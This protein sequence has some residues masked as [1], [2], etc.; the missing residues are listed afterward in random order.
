MVVLAASI[1]TRQGKP[2]LSR[3]FQEITKERV[4]E[5][6][7]KF[8][9]LVA[10][11]S[12]DHTFVEDGHVRFVYKP[13]DNYYI[14]LIT[15]KQSNI[16]QDLSSLNL[17]AQT[18]SS[19]LGGSY[20]E[21]ELYSNAFEIIS[22]FD[23]ILTMGYREN[24]T[25]NQVET[26]LSMESHE[27]RI[28]E[29][30][31]RNKEIEA[32]EERKRRAKEISNR[33]RARKQGIYTGMDTTVTGQ[34]MPGSAMAGM[35]PG[36]GMGNYGGAGM[37]GSGGQRFQGSSDP[38]VANA[39]NS[40]YGHGSQ[41]AGQSYLQSHMEIHQSHVQGKGMKLSSGGSKRQQSAMT[42]RSSGNFARA[43]STS[44]T[45]LEETKL[46]N[47]GILLNIKESCS[48]EIT[49]DGAIQS[50]ELKGVLEVRV[51]DKS[52]AHAIFHLNEIIDP[53]DK[54]LQY[55]THP[56]IDK[57]RFTSN[58]VLA[59]KD[60]NKAFPANDNSLGIL[61]W[62][63]TGAHDDKSIVPL[64]IS[65]W[66]SPSD[67][68]QGFYEMTIELEAPDV[69]LKGHAIQE[70]QLQIPLFSENAS[71][72][73]GSSD[74][75]PEILNIDD[76]SGVTVKIHES[77]KSGESATISLLLEAEDED[78]IFP[79]RLQF[80]SDELLDSSATESKKLSILGT[81]VGITNVSH[82]LEEDRG[83][84]PYDVNIALRSEDFLVI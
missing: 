47:N 72:N 55:K 64:E 46:P 80:K 17:F 20:D 81:N 45:E 79:I 42:A 67:E 32:T 75:K 18:V 39:Y 13:F 37:Q 33:E 4:L 70:L 21:S 54:S 14:I 43:T 27:E 71:I 66:V 23:E 69:L 82:A 50:S 40:Y 77:L 19:Y 2:L 60:P 35:N 3:Q 49:R 58:K 11:I 52:L 26:Y 51:N 24:L 36:S 57:N 63:K 59:L 38:N 78:A 30:I 68:K 65:A 28:Q 41:A 31:E 5:L 8:Q 84:L 48:A 73:E 34:G 16:V 9:S 74:H 29:I 1:T 10:S 6:L 7:S 44:N 56:N 53:K 62:R 61:R 83:A 25:V 12:S 15:N 22:A 76:E